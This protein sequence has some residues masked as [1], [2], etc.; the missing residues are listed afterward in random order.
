[1]A[2]DDN[3]LIPNA[4]LR[5]ILLAVHDI[6][7]RNGLIA[8]L[9]SAGMERFVAALPP[10][11]QALEVRAAE[12]GSI[13]GVIETQYG[14]GARGQLTRIGYSTFQ[15]L[16]ASD[17]IGWTLLGLFLRGLPGLERQ[18]RALGKLARYL[19]APAGDVRAFV[20]EAHIVFEDA[21]SDETGGRAGATEDSHLSI[22]MLQACVE[23]ATGETADI[24]Q[25]AHKARGDPASRFEIVVPS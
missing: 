24:V 21:A 25:V 15:H 22:G 18:R 10:D 2:A 7:G 12:L 11:D 3:R 14:R 5:H 23:W 16:Q 4:R 20:A 6:M 1:M 8:V 17:R 13:V 19:A 9:K